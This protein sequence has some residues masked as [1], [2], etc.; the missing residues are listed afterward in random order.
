MSLLLEY[1]S[2]RRIVSIIRFHDSID[3]IGSLLHDG[4]ASRTKKEI[5]YFLRSIRRM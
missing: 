2:N 4:A 1:T 3:E 5:S